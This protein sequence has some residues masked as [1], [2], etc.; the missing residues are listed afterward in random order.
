MCWGIA[1]LL[2]GTILPPVIHDF[3]ESE[4]DTELIIDSYDSELYEEWLTN[5]DSDDPAEYYQI[6]AWNCT[7]IPDV[8]NGAVPIVVEVGP[9]M[10]RVS[11]RKI[12]LDGQMGVIW[13]DDGSWSP[14][15]TGGT[16]ARYTPYNFMFWDQK[17]SI[18][19]GLSP[20]ADPQKDIVCT[21]SKIYA[22]ATVVG[23]GAG[24]GPLYR[25]GAR[26]F[27]CETGVQ[28]SGVS[29]ENLVF[30]RPEPYIWNYTDPQDAIDNNMEWA[31][32]TGRLNRKLVRRQLMWR[33]VKQVDTLWFEEDGEVWHEYVRGTDA[34][35]FPR[36]LEKG[37]RLDVWEKDIIRTVYL[38]NYDDEESTYKDIDL[39]NFRVEPET[40][41]SCDV[42]PTNCVFNMTENG[43]IN[44]E[45]IALGIPLFA[46]QAH[47]YGVDEIYANTTIG[48]TPNRDIHTSY[49]NVEP[50]T[51]ITMN[52]GKV[53]QVNI[54]IGPTPL[55]LTEIGGTFCPYE[56][57]APNTYLPVIWF[58]EGGS[59]NDAKADEFKEGVVF[60]RNFIKYSE[61]IFLVFAPLMLIP[62][63]FFCYKYHGEVFAKR[64]QYGTL[65][66]DYDTQRLVN[67]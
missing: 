21:V 8:V 33:N 14:E 39:L 53:A 49:I 64:N 37:Q 52:A 1:L 42:Y 15:N 56:N 30:G 16:S 58:I 17:E 54:R 60:G 12:T 10:Y 27:F 50:Y 61:I 51:G 7:N 48:Q 26:Y 35:Q 11:K 24:E 20:D 29:V 4:L 47:M 3:I 62:G 43:L 23:G 18:N 55:C 9:Y 44:L 34:S 5:E 65:A 46:S 2:L 31:F 41:Y 57:V 6:Y 19:R 67:P 63:V 45:A 22:G 36:K 28:E 13:G 59:I 40:Y 38:K 66:G 32:D 25:T